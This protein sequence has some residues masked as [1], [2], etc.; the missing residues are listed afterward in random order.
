MLPLR[1]AFAITFH[2]SQGMTINR[3]AVNLGDTEA[4]AGGTFT[5]L[6]RVPSLGG[7]ALERPINHDRLSR[8]N[9]SKAL[10]ARKEYER[11]KWPPLELAARNHFA[12]LLTEAGVLCAPDDPVTRLGQLAAR[13]F[14]G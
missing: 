10:A 11:E 2:K 1:L 4:H 12:A 9:H 7:L 13:L 5:A 8:V 3:M 6:S 14:T